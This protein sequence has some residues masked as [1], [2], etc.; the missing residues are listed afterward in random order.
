[1]ESSEEWRPVEG[2]EG[3][4]E[5]SFCGRIKSLIRG[6]LLCPSKDRYGHMGILLK[7]LKRYSIHRLVA[8][9]FIPNPE[10]HP[11]VRH[12]DGNPANNVVSNLRWGTQSENAKDR[13][14]HGTD[15]YR[16]RTHCP[17]GHEYTDENTYWNG[18]RRKCRACQRQRSREYRN[19]KKDS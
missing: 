4:Y 12:Y 9:A 3:F 19:R 17:H 7:D 6:R 5:I 2:F 13:I 14:R 8:K 16:N 11:I 10:N 15:P 18:P 1:M